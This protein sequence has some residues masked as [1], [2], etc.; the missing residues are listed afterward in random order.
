L[1]IAF[2]GYKAAGEIDAIVAR[3]RLSMENRAEQGKATTSQI[4]ISHIDV[5]EYGRKTEKLMVNEKLR[6]LWDAL[7]KIILRGVAW[8]NVETEIEKELGEVKMTLPAVDR[9]FYRQFFNR[10]VHNPIF[11]GH[12]AMYHNNSEKGYGKLIGIF[13]PEAYPIPEGVKLFW[14]THEPIWT[15]QLAENIKHELL[16]RHETSLGNSRSDKPNFFRALC[17]CAQCNSIMQ[18]HPDGNYKGLR[19]KMAQDG[20]RRCNNRQIVNEKKILQF[21]DNF[22]HQLILLEHPDFVPPPKSMPELVAEKKKLNKNMNSLDEEIRD[23]IVELLRFEPEDVK[24]HIRAKILMLESR[25]QVSKRDYMV[26]NA[27]IQ[28]T[29]EEVNELKQ[30][31]ETVTELGLEQFWKQDPVY[32]NRSLRIILGKN[33]ILLDGGQIIGVAKSSKSGRRNKSID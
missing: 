21:V 15:G 1:F 28:R 29:K 3:R 14:N 30:D 6:P 31:I 17:L 32:I 33:R 8:R 5:D 23:A 7:A 18:Y 12:S 16:R 26:I 10:L 11:W 22:L 2:A 19:C 4:P 9:T 20:E 24:K 13:N 27:A 25:L